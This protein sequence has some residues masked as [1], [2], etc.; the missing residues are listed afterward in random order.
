MRPWA[1]CSS[2]AFE[3]GVIKCVNGHVFRDTDANPDMAT[4]FLLAAHS[5]SIDS[6]TEARPDLTD[7]SVEDQFAVREAVLELENRP[8]YVDQPCGAAAVAA[9]EAQHQNLADEVKDAARRQYLP[10]GAAL[11]PWP[12]Y[13]VCEVLTQVVAGNNYFLKIRVSAAS[14]TPAEFVWLRVFESLFGDPPQL[15]ELRKGAEA[16]G[17]IRY[18]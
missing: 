17:P 11:T 14:T 13:S 9:V 10:D 1:W 4:S 15:V 5:R 18:F 2:S 6:G 16:A 8:R 12:A 3:P 7:S